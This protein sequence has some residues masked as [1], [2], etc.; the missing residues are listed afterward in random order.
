MSFKF[1]VSSFEFRAEARLLGRALFAS[2]L[3]FSLCF[4]YC[5]VGNNGPLLT[6]GLPLELETQN[7]FT[8]RLLIANVIDYGSLL[9]DKESQTWP[10]K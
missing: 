10:A 8:Q 1:Q 7:S 3:C 5:F 6:R 4:L 9:P 2:S